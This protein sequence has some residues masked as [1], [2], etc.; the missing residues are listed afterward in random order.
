LHLIAKVSQPRE[1]DLGSELADALPI[2]RD[3]GSADIAYVA[4]ALHCC[5]VQYQLRYPWSLKGKEA[6]GQVILSAFT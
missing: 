4:R 1:W 5:E 2:R 6:R 3:R